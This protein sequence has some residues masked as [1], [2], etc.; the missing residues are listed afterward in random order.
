MTFEGLWSGLTHPKDFPS[1]EWKPQF[2]DLIGASHSRMYN[3]WRE[4]GIASDAL[5]NIAER[6]DP[7]LLESELKDQV[8]R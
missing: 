4:E 3:I 6:D 7:R 2:K 5:Q 8:G 1:N